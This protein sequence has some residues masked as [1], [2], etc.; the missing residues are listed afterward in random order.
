MVCKEA[1]CDKNPSDTSLEEMDSLGAPNCRLPTH[2][3][4]QSLI[5][6][7]FAV[8]PLCEPTFSMALTTF[9]LSSPDTCPKT[10]C[11]PSSHCV[12]TVQRK[13]WEPFVFGPA[14]AIDRMPGPVCFSVKFSSANF[15][16]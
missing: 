15:C 4:P 11:L 9:I 13:N 6:T 16:P 12:F 8:L 5:T 7:S 2:N 1:K 14:F 3:W 10:T